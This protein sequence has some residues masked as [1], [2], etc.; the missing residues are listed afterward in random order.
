M[1]DG[2]ADDG[3]LLVLAVCSLGE[4]WVFA[5][6]RKGSEKSGWVLIESPELGG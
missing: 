2:D 5:A 1:T 3:A 4:V 6:G